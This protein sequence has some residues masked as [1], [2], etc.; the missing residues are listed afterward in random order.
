MSTDTIA[1][2]WDCY[3]LESA[4]NISD[5]DKKRT[6]AVLRGEESKK[7][8]VPPNLLHWKLRAQYNPQRHYEIYVI[9]VQQ[10]ITV[11]D[12]REAFEASPQHMAETI[13]RIGHRFY[14]NPMNP[15]QVKITS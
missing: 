1:L 2:M 5:I 3:G 4:V 15:D 7:L 6:W 9:T 10:G 8:P 11:D 14:G 13:R 12:I